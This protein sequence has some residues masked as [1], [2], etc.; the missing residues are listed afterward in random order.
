MRLSKTLASLLILLVLIAAVRYTEDS[1]L[2]PLREALHL[3]VAPCTAP[4]T[5]SIGSID[6][7]FGISST[8][9]R[10]EVAQAADMWQKPAQKTLFEYK[11]KGGDVTVRLVYDERQETTQQLASDSADIA[12]GKTAYDTTKMRYDTLVAQVEDERA[13]YAALQTQYESALDAYN[14]EVARWNARGGAPPSVY[15]QLAQ[16]KESL[17]QQKQTLGAAQTALNA[18]IATLN[19]LGAQLNIQA[20]TVNGDVMHYNQTGASL[21][22]FEEGLYEQNEAGRTITIYSYASKTKLLRVLAHEMGH[23][24]GLEHVNDPEAIMYKVN[25]GSSLFIT[26][27]DI[28]ALNT[29]CNAEAH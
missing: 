20:K 19:A 14:S 17:T 13:R 15:T 16:Q 24:L 12:V 25:T 11:E 3:S 8:T 7:R 1:W 26:A 29:L 22:E 27:A 5:Y 18:D 28:Q 21:G 4:I 9:L 23:A 10:A 2:V 6:P